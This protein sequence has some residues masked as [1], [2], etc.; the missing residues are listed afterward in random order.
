MNWE[1][2]LLNKFYKTS[3]FKTKNYNLLSIKSLTF[4]N[5]IRDLIQKYQLTKLNINCNKRG[6]LYCSV[7]SNKTIYYDYYTNLL[8]NQLSH[9]ITINEKYCLKEEKELLN[10]KFSSTL[11]K[12]N[13]PYVENETFYNFVFRI[14]LDKAS[15]CEQIL[16]FEIIEE[17]LINGGPYL[18]GNK[19][20]ANDIIS[21]SLFFNTHFFS[22]KEE[23][24]M[25]FQ[26]FKQLY[27]LIEKI[28]NVR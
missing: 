25:K 15:E 5:S 23:F 1:C 21:V 8:F 24:F 19:L 11:I 13:I 12:K 27:E 6:A 18:H 10:V 20:N 9:I 7:N 4:N 22:K 2:T 28:L 14:L 16:Y 17:I 26:K 3:D